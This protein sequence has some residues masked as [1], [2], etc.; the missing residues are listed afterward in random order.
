MEATALAQRMK[1]GKLVAEK[2]LVVECGL[3]EKAEERLASATALVKAIAKE[4]G[5]EFEKGAAEDLAEFVAADLIRLKTDVQKLATYMAEK[6]LL[7]RDDVSA[8]AV[9]E[10]TQKVR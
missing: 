2:T 6:K 10:P 9:S 5:V 1:L 3:G 7:G 4:E 8:L